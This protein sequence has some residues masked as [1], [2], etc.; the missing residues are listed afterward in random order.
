MLS[1]A[2]IIINF[3]TPDLTRR[4]VESFRLYYPTVPLLLI[5]NGSP[6]NSV[7]MFELFRT[8]HT[9][10]IV[11]RT[12]QHHGPAMDQAMRSIETQFA[13]FLDSDCTVKRGGF[14]ELMCETLLSQKENYAIG[15][16]I[17]MNPRGFDI[18]ESPTAISYIRPYCM[19][20]N[21]EYYFSLP[22]FSKHG[23]P[24]LANMQAAQERHLLLYH[25]PVD[26]YV[27]HKGRG[28]ASR[29]GY[30]LGI[31]GKVNHLLN[32]LGL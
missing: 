14:L 8:A 16:R 5:D 18:A 31:R 11:N 32:K 15:K 3:Q 27:E 13:F 17:F 23:A 20:V 9:R 19:V 12:N 25:F 30:H 26:E 28:T 24:C 1:I 6:D 21:R 4:A 2:A 10:L 7:Q 29:H 22:P